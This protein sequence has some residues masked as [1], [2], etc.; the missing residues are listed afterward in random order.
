MPVILVKDRKEVCSQRAEADA[1]AKY[2]HL[3][4]EKREQYS[5]KKEV[6]IMQEIMCK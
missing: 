1:S 4:Q 5:A 2:D 3:V 6:K